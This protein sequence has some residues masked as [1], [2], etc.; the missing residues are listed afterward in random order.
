MSVIRHA[1]QLNN[2]LINECGQACSTM[3]VNAYRGLSL[4]VEQLAAATNTNKGRFTPFYAYNIFNDDGTVKERVPG[5]FDML[6]HYSIR[7]AWTNNATWDWYQRKWTDGYPVIALVDYTQFTDNR[8]Y[9]AAH[10]L[11]ATGTR[12]DEVVV[13]D[14]LQLSG[15]TTVPIAEFKQAIASRSRYTGGTNDPHQAMFPLKPLVPSALFSDRVQ[16]V[17]DSIRLAVG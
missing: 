14:P 12:G 8:G 2:R 15:P 16:T 3:L 11:I 1:T 17:A 10:F 4:T 13:Y 9:W 7:A 6:E 5:L